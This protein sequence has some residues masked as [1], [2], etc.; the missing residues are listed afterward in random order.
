LPPVNSVLA[1]SFVPSS[2]FCKPHGIRR[3]DYLSID[4]E[5][6]EWRILHDFDVAAF[7][8]KVISVENNARNDKLRRHLAQRGCRLVRTFGGFDDLYA[9]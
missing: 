7:E 5:G 2:L 4:T 1:V 3:I 9:R 8:I 6:S